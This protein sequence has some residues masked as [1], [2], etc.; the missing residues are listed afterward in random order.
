[1]A[2]LADPSVC[3]QRNHFRKRLAFFL[4]DPGG[5]S[6]DGVAIEHGDDTL[7]DDWT[8]VVGIVGE[9]HCAAADFDSHRQRGLVNFGAVKSFPAEGGDQRGVDVDHSALV[10]AGDLYER[11]EPSQDD[12]VGLG[13]TDRIENGGAELFA[14]ASGR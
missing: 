13:V 2:L 14:S 4:E 8:C 11:Q 7:I 1:M 5:Q 12:Q 6:V 9:V 10:L 3:V